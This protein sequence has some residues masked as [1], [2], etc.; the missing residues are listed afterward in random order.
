MYIRTIHILY[1]PHKLVFCAALIRMKVR[2][3]VKC[4]PLGRHYTYFILHLLHDMVDGYFG[5]PVI[6]LIPLERSND[7]LFNTNLLPYTYGLT[8]FPRYRNTGIRFQ[9]HQPYSTIDI[10]CA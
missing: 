7:I 10:Y 9:Y 2:R 3:N 1:C 4:S 5:K 6:A 8:F